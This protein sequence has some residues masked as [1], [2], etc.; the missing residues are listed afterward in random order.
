M[1]MYQLAFAFSAQ[2]PPGEEI[3]AEIFR[4]HH[5]KIRL[6]VY[7]TLSAPAALAPV[8]IA[9]DYSY[10]LT[11]PKDIGVG[12]LRRSRYR[13]IGLLKMEHEG[14]KLLWLVASPG[15]SEVMDLVAEALQNLGGVETQD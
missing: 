10:S 1:G 2:F 8:T 6:A 13:A 3:L 5:I 12:W 9:P 14:R 4:R 7:T 11:H 15:Q